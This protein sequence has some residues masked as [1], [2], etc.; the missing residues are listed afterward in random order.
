[1]KTIKKQ[2]I[3]KLIKEFLGLDISLEKLDNNIV[4]EI[5]NAYDEINDEIDI[6]K[7]HHI[8]YSL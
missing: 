7:I 4:I 6:M 1:M 5:E 3:E 2:K 8:G